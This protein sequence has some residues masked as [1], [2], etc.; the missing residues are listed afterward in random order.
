MKAPEVFAGWECPV[1]KKVMKRGT[2]RE[3]IVVPNRNN[4]AVMICVPCSEI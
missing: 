3:P 2:D 1:C 4:H